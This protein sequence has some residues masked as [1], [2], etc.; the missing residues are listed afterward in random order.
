M[1]ELSEL[2][3][4]RI[5]YGISQEKLARISTLGVNT[6]AKIETGAAHLQ[7]PTA[8]KLMKAIEEYESTAELSAQ[9][10]LDSGD[11]SGFD[12]ATLKSWRTSYGISQEK[13]AKLAKLGVNT[14][15][16]IELGVTQIMP[17]TASKLK[18][19]VRQ[20]ESGEI[21]IPKAESAGDHMAGFDPSELRAWRKKHGISQEK[22][23]RISKLGV[24]TILK[25]E[26]GTKVQKD[27][28]LSLMQAVKEI[29]KSIK[30]APTPEPTV[31]TP[32][33]SAVKPVTA[34]TAKPV[35]AQPAKPVAA[36]KSASHHL[37][38][39]LDLKT[40]RKRFGLSQGKLAELAQLSLNTIMK[41]ESGAKDVQKRTIDR[42]LQAIKA[43]EGQF[44]S[45]PV[46]SPKVAAPVEVAPEVIA[47]VAVTPVVASQVATA[48]VAKH[49][50]SA[51]AVRHAVPLQLTNL[52]LELINRVILMNTKQKL[53]MLELMMDQDGEE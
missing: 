42:L 6:I 44:T 27:T 9:A 5:K 50:E 14:I 41:M 26:G 15:A 47:P 45:A 38:S 31:E 3:A 17:Q 52:D 8:A 39:N 1:S 7:E 19:I 13:L 33:V 53:R 40:W 4:W 37:G 25:L 35:T 51:P 29:N 28:L 11:S 20:V 21:P 34:P 2:R 10:E 12:I 36:A 24:N 43:V 16:K 46:E 22:L 30:T 23:A 32:P 48:P 49:V 18:Q